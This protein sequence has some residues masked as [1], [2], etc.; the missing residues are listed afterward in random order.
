MAIF[1]L[2][3]GVLRTAIILP[4]YVV[5]PRSRFD[6]PFVLL[7]GALLALARGAAALGVWYSGWLGGMHMQVMSV[8]QGFD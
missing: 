4:W 2:S 8:S 3:S 6:L 5:R 1:D 7:T